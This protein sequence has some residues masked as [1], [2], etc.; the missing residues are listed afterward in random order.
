MGFAAGSSTR[1]LEVIIM[2]KQLKK[3][4]LV[5]V[6][7]DQGTEVGVVIAVS[8]DRVKVLFDDGTISSWG[9]NVVEVSA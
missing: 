9:L 4:D 3:G 5:A 1:T 6:T 2:R 8:G 7:H